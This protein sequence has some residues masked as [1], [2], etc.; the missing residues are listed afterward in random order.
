LANVGKHRDNTS[1]HKGVSWYKR[2]KK[3]RAKININNKAIHIGYFDNLEDAATAY[4][5]AALKY[6]GEFARS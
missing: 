4:Q 3:W 5:A 2:D 6:F 1:G